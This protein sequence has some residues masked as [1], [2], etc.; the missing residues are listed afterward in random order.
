MVVR[1]SVS[2]SRYMAPCR[3]VSTPSDTQYATECR[4]QERDFFFSD[5]ETG[6]NSSRRQCQRPNGGEILIMVRDE[7]KA[8]SVHHDESEHWA[9]SRHEKQHGDFHGPADIFSREAN[10]HAET[11]YGQW[12]QVIKRVGRRDQPSRIDEGEL[13]RPK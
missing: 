2:M 7:R 4:L 6:R 12:P 11:S 8:K 1:Q 3:H 13:H 9:E 5:S 10:H